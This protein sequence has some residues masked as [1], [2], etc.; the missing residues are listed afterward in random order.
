MRRE[1]SGSRK[2]EL[3][4][5]PGEISVQEAGRRGGCATRDRRGIEVLRKIAKRG[6]ETTKKRYAHLFSEFG[7]RGGRPRRPA[8]SESVGEKDQQ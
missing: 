7:R 8:L 3:T 1:K 6:G 2:D 5:V 4:E